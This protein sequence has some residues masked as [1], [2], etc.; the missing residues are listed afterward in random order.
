MDGL[1][2]ATFTSRVELMCHLTKLNSRSIKPCYKHEKD[3]L[4]I[5]VY[6]PQQFE[7]SLVSNVNVYLKT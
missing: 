6:G 4:S 5:V 2:V 3:T 1:Y 7:I